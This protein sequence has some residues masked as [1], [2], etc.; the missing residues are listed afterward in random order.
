MVA[1]IPS[2]ATCRL[3]P[4]PEM[5]SPKKVSNFPAVRLDYINATRLID[6]S[7]MVFWSGNAM[8]LLEV[9]EAGRQ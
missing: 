2:F 9:L 6:G 5:F 4:A 8:E 7:L 1:S 3:I